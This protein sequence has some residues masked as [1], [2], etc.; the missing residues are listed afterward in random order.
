MAKEKSKQ[1]ILE[2]KIRSRWNNM[3]MLWK[4]EDITLF[5]W[6]QK[7]RAGL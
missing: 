2:Q 4:E 1:E 7:K 5:V 6:N 3:M